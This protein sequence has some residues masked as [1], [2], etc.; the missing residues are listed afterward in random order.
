MA[1]NRRKNKVAAIYDVRQAAEEKA[2]A[3]RDLHESPSSDAR[4]ALLDAQI[5]LEAKTL[6]AIEACNECGHVHKSSEP[7]ERIVQ[8]KDNVLDVDFAGDS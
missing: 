8:R 6:D 2:L 3:E 4:D 7:H 1:R 5:N